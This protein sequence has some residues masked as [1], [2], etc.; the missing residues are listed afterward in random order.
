MEVEMEK[1]WLLCEM[2]MVSLGS[3]AL[4]AIPYLIATHH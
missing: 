3:F 1:F 2:A 4:V